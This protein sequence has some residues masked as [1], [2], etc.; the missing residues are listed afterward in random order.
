MTEHMEIVKKL[1]DAIAKLLDENGIA[2]HSFGLDGNAKI[3]NPTV[4]DQVCKLS[5]AYRTI[6]G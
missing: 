6:I 4:V 1:G 5:A 3:L 2:D